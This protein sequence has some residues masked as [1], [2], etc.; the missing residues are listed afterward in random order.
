[1]AKVRVTIK[2]YMG[3]DE[4]SWAV[5][6]DGRPKWTGLGLREARYYRDLERKKLG[7]K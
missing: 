1:M 4:L 2:K 6:I 5:F 3:D 7:C